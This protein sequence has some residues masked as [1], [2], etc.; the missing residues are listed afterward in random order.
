MYL[1]DY[2]SL[3]KAVQLTL[4]ECLAQSTCYLTEEDK[5]DWENLPEFGATLPDWDT[6]KQALFREY[7]NARKPFIS[8]ADLG[9]FIDEKSKQEIHT[10]D[11]FTAFHWEFRRLET[12]L[13]KEKRVS[14]NGLNRVYKKSIHPELWEKILLYLSDEKTPCVKEEAFAVEYVR[15]G[16]EHILEGFDH[17]YKISQPSTSSRTFPAPPVKSEM[18]E[19]LNVIAMMGQNFQMV[20]SA[21]QSNSH[22]RPQ[23]LHT[24]W[25][26]SPAL[27][28]WTIL[29][30]GLQ[31]IAVS[32]AIRWLIS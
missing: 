11:D 26:V 28:G 18:S 14:A 30:Q 25:L 32:C 8:S 23:D 12:R 19:V 2:E 22:P 27:K 10:L 1:S 4:G 5:D 20:M 7:P 16:A 21:L 17:L 13:A 31:A 6:F 24:S 9:I 15:E 3:A 29:T